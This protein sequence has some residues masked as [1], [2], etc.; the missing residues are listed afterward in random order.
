MARKTSH[1]IV[2][3]FVVFGTLLAA[4]LIIWVGAS[5]YFEKGTRYVTFFDES[6]QGLQKDSPVKYRGVEVGRVE[7]IRVAA[8]NRLIEVLMNIDL[9]E[10]VRKNLIAE[11]KSVGITGIVF[12]ELTRLEAGEVPVPSKIDFK[13]SYPVVPSRS[14]TIREVVTK[15]E[16]VVDKISKVDF[17]GIS[18]QVKATGESA[19][20]LFEG[21][22]TRRVIENLE[23]LSSRLDR[24]AARLDN[25]YSNERLTRIANAAEADAESLGR[26]IARVDAEVAKANL[27]DRSAEARALIADSKALVADART[28]VAGA[29]TLLSDAGTVVTDARKEIREMKLAETGQ[30]AARI[31]ESFEEQQRTLLPAARESVDELRRTSSELRELVKQLKDSPSELLFSNPPP[32][33]Q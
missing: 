9:A 29:R 14:S 13:T 33:R 16:D 12:V 3:L 7:E 30:S 24:F 2:G 5:R 26:L 11:L 1:V 4:S 15:V 18:E 28:V 19:E 31:A 27:G 21:A 10:G 22:G 32:H 17:E 23:R 8:D 20:R 25:V 6:V